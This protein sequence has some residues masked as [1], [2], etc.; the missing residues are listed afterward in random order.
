MDEP[1]PLA[2]RILVGVCL[3]GGAWTVRTITRRAA[4]GRLGRNQLAGLRTTATLRSD[5]AWR[6]GHRAGL[7]SNEIGATGLA[8]AG[9]AILVL[10]DG[11]ALIAVSLGGA[12]WAV[13]WLLHAMVLA[14]RAAR[15]VEP[16]R[17][18][19]DDEK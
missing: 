18:A 7:P 4:D 11:V 16:D 13:G 2:A 15:V 6:A 9:L 5:E 17:P 3:L 10:P 12:V 14:N 8:L 1:I 19:A